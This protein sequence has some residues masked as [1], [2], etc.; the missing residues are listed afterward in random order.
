MAVTV[1]NSTVQNRLML[2]MCHIYS[3]TT[4]PIYYTSMIY[5]DSG[6]DVMDYV[7]NLHQWRMIER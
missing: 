5:Y 7:N 4:P 3:Y 2:Y 1:V 6:M